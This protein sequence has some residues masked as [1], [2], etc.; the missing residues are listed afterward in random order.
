MIAMIERDSDDLPVA[1]QDAARHLRASPAPSDLWRQR[2]LH[3]IASAPAPTGEVGAARRARVW[4]I[5]P[6]AAIAAAIVFMAVGGGM[7][8]MFRP[9]PSPSRQALEIQAVPGVARVRFS[10]VAPRASAVSI[11]GDFN[12]WNPRTLPLR[13]AAD[14]RT[15]EVEVPLAPGRYAYSFVVDGAIARDPSAPQSTDDDFGSPSSV[16]M[17]SGS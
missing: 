10:L 6:I 16:L 14:G 2:L 11:V 5:R 1:L 17:V 13:R 4:S 3:V 8:L 9:S 7:A 12:Q 15:W